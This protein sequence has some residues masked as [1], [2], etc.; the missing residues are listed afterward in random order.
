[1]VDR[2]GSAELRPALFQL[3]DKLAREDLDTATLADV[4]R[5]LH[6]MLPPGTA[7]ASAKLARDGARTRARLRFVKRTP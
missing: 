2:R 4:E 5:T 3:R 6:A 1:M 7:R